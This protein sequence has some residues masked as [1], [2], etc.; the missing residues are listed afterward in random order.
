MWRQQVGES[1]DLPNSGSISVPRNP[2]TVDFDYAITSPSPQ[3][4]NY[5][6]TISQLI[7]SNVKGV[8]NTNITQGET[9]T[10]QFQGS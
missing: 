10:F 3:V 5:Q 2:S 4:I 9:Q 8:I 7:P 1:E 6:V